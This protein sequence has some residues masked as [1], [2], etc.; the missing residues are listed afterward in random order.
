MNTTIG[1]KR[2][3]SFATRMYIY[4]Y[5]RV[6]YFSDRLV[7]WFCNCASREIIADPCC[8]YSISAGSNLKGD[9]V[10]GGWRKSGRERGLREKSRGKNAGKQLAR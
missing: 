2:E 6:S 1:I 7:Y 10:Q 5:I 8:Q 3:T 9:V 4:I